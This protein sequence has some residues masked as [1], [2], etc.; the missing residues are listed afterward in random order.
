MNFIRQLSDKKNNNIR[1]FI[2]VN[3]TYL[4]ILILLQ[5]FLDFI[6]LYHLARFISYLIKYEFN[7]IRVFYSQYYF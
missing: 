7:F 6:N 5:S 2:I 1:F 4:I 3:K